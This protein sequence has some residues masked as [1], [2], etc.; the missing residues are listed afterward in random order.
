MRTVA[1]LAR[2]QLLYET[3]ESK[4]EQESSHLETAE[5]NADRDSKLVQTRMSESRA[6][7]RATLRL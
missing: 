1:E 2:Q 7:G 5:R 3:A 4:V 6:Y